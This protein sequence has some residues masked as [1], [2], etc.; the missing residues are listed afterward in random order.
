MKIKF[1]QNNIEGITSTPKATPQKINHNGIEYTYVGKSKESPAM[2]TRVKALFEC[3][4]MTLGSCL[5]I[6]CFFKGFRKTFKNAGR[7]LLSGQEIVKYYAINP[8]VFT[9]NNKTQNIQ[10]PTPDENFKRGLEE[11]KN[12]EFD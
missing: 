9:Q 6:P 11:S 5:V 3:F 12:V 10:P 2:T 4:I 8:H 7:E 1:L